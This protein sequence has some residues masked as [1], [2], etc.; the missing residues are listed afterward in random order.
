MGW[1]DELSPAADTS[2]QCGYQQVC[3]AAPNSAPVGVRENFMCGKNFPTDTSII[4]SYPLASSAGRK[5]TQFGPFSFGSRPGG[6]W[7]VKQQSP[8]LLNELTDH[9]RQ[10]YVPTTEPL[11]SGPVRSEGQEVC[12]LAW[13]A[14]D[15]I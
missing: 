13:L 15:L 1:E 14:G 9:N 7:L 6:G 3:T 4:P 12:G 8:L 11:L 2:K 5:Y 10:P